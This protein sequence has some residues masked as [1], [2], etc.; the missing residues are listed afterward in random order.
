LGD[1][2]LD[3]DDQASKKSERLVILDRQ[4][5]KAEMGSS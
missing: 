5:V 2:I 3:F 4:L 1:G